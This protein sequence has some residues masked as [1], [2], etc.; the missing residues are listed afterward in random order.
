MSKKGEKEVM[1]C[2]SV[3]HQ[4]GAVG[5]AFMCAAAEQAPGF[6]DA[7]TGEDMEDL[8]DKEQVKQDIIA[9]KLKPLGQEHVYHVFPRDKK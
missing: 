9:G 2:F 6:I 1:A 3:G 8:L 7:N 4:L 5:T